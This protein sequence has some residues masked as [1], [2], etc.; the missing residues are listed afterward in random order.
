MYTCTLTLHKAITAAWPLSFWIIHGVFWAFRKL[1]QTL[2][3]SIFI[4]QLKY[5]VN[6]LVWGQQIAVF[7]ELSMAGFLQSIDRLES[8][9]KVCYSGSYT[10][11][12]SLQPTDLS[13]N[14]LSNVLKAAQINQI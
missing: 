14:T 6:H 10:D 4:N 8:D 11:Y 5:P 13:R 3:V 9:R 12:I 2:T 7:I 1:L